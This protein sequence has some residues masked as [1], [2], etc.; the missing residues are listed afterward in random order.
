MWCYT[1]ARN[2]P[3]LWSARVIEAYGFSQQPLGSSIPR[4]PFSSRFGGRHKRVGL[5]T[6]LTPVN[7][8]GVCLAPGVGARP[9]LRREYFTYG[10][11]CKGRSRW[12]TWPPSAPAKARRLANGS[13]V[14]VISSSALEEILVWSC[15]LRLAAYIGFYL[16]FIKSHHQIS[17]RVSRSR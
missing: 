17:S 2:V 15:W 1:T 8:P 14:G 10:Y 7:L 11:H 13:K 9:K 5:D 6:S 12:Y 3:L 16:L 4:L